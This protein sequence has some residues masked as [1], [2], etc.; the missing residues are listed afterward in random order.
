MSLGESRSP[1]G[2]MTFPSS[3]AYSPSRNGWRGR[4]SSSRSCPSGSMVRLRYRDIPVPAGMSFPMMTFSFSP[5]SG[6]CFPL[7]A[8]SVRTRVVSWKLAAERNDSVASDAFVTPSRT[9]LP[10]AGVLPSAF[11]R[12]FS[13]LNW[14]SSMSCPGRYRVSPPSTIFTFRS[15]VRT[16]NFL[17][18]LDQIVLQRRLTLDPQDVVRVERAFVELIAGFDPVAVV[19][20]QVHPHRD[21]V[22]MLVAPVV[23]DDHVPFVALFDDTHR[24]GDLGHR[25]LAFRLA[26]FE[27]FLDA[28][29][30]RDDVFGRD[31]AGMEGPQRQLRPGLADRL[32]GDDPDGLADID[33]APGR[34]IAAVAHRAD[35]V[36]GLTRQHRANLDG[37]DP[38]LEDQLGGVLI[39][40]FVAL[41]DLQAR[42]LGMLDVLGGTPADDTIDEGFDRLLPDANVGH[43]D[44]LRGPAVV[45][46]DDDVLRHVD[47]TPRQVAGVGRA[48]RGVGQTLTRTV[49]R[50]EVL[51][52]G[53]PFFERGLDRDFEDAPR[54]I[55]HETAHTA[56]LL[57][58]RDRTARTRSRHH[59]DGVERILRGLH[60]GRNVV[61]RLRPDVDRLVVLFFRRDETLIEE[62]VQIL[63][64]VLR[65]LQDLVLL[66]RDDDVVDRNRRPRER[67]I[68]EPERLDRVQELR[69]LGVAVTTIAVGDQA[70]E[71]VLVDDVIDV[72]MPP[73]LGERR[74][75]NAAAHGR[76]DPLHLAVFAGRDADLDP[77]LEADL[78]VLVGVDRVLQI[79]EGREPPALLDVPFPVGRLPVGRGVAVLP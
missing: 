61:R 60:R 66:R 12:S 49:R 21:F 79:G 28:R 78:L 36:L 65:L 57:D 9:G 24:P 51:E 58:L 72:R 4:P 18:F 40:F 10:S 14:A 62:P 16:V 76:L 23:G 5:R 6:S 48:Q 69:R 25:G 31:A 17:D 67:R 59:E 43:G 55:A 71:L 33:L 35:A 68:A 73:L 47:Q 52:D 41:D 1:L 50:D 42:V 53:E 56:E 64:L 2:P 63:D 77:L 27:D 74:V 44:P 75:E 29:Q 32:R 26:C 38:G 20:H 19:H 54:R 11:I 13:S 70:L 30:T 8:A 7:I 45:L 46:A 34:E 22:A 39:D 3:S 37:G 15:I